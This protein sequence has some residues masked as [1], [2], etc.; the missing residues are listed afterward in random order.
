[1][2]LLYIILCCYRKR[3]S[4]IYSRPKL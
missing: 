3:R 1:M 2:N 4:K